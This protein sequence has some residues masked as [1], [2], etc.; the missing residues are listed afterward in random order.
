MNIEAVKSLFTLFTG[1]NDVE[2]YMPIIELAISE[3]QKSLVPG[4][5]IGDTRLGFLCAATANFR[6]C[7]INAARDRTATTIGG[8]MLTPD[9]GGGILAHA[10]K[11]LM[12]YMELCE[13]LITSKAF[14]FIANA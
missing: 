10:E 12:D 6:L 2:N 14:M 13:D 9:T 4:A 8:K 7:Q 11:L 1:E 3:V 5:D